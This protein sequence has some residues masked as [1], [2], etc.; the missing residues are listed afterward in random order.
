M[1]SLLLLALVFAEC[2]L[3][4]IGG[5]ASTLPEMAHLVVDVH[6]WATAPQFAALFGL[7]QAAPGPNMLISTL[8]GE[9][10]AGLPGA[11][12]ATAA[13][14]TPSGMLALTVSRIWDRFEAAPW[15]RIVQAAITPIS[16]GLILAGA[17]YLIRAAD[18]DPFAYAISFGAAFI[19]LRS[20]LHPL[21][22]LAGGVGLGL[23]GFA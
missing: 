3:L 16:S 19:N 20:K 4:A 8:I 12:V 1:I 13:M 11:L 7:G 18:H 21:W 23:V 14:I 5:V 15:R 10:V 6:H 2:S 17:A 9:R 22:L